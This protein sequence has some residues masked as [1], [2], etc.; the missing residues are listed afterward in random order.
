MEVGKWILEREEAKLHMDNI[1]TSICATLHDDSGNPK[2]Q[3]LQSNMPP[4]RT[5]ITELTEKIR[6]GYFVFDSQIPL[7]PSQKKKATPQQLQPIT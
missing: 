6:V 2:I 4:V 5:R 7:S 1:L 3:H